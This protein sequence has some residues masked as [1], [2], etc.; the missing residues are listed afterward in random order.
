MRTFNNLILE[1]KDKFKPIKSF[2]LKDDLN[3]DVWEEN[4][5]INQD[6]REKLL[7]ISNDFLKDNELD[8]YD[9]YDIILTGSNCNYNWSEYSDYDL[10]I[11][12]DFKNINEDTDLV[13]KYFKSLCSNWNILHDIKIDKYEVEIYLQDE[14]EKHISSGQFS[15]KN[16]E[17]IIK[18]EKNNFKPDENLIKMKSEYI[19]DVIDSI[20]KNYN[21]GKSYDELIPDIKKIWSKIKD[22]R[23]AGLNKEGEYSIENLVFKLLRRNGY[24][25]KL[26]DIRTKSYDS[27]FK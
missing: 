9:I 16:N 5:E 12:L 17:W 10:H 19:I 25:G 23:R 24:I 8:K 11:V 6:I 2:Y 13:S 3:R 7:D 14:N 20:E 18:P 22:S 27:K 26:I 4:D 1:N 15:L 21:N